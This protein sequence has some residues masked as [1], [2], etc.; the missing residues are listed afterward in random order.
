MVGIYN[1]KN[2]ISL[3]T[4]NNDKNFGDVPTRETIAAV[5]SYFNLLKTFFLKVEY[6]FR[7]Y[8]VIIILS[9]FD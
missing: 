5:K 7:M 9:F 2:W 1:E 4:M 3:R 8:V 6:I